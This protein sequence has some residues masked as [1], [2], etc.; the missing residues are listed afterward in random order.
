MPNLFFERN[1][2][3][4]G[5]NAPAREAAAPKRKRVIFFPQK[6]TTP[7]FRPRGGFAQSAGPNLG[8]VLYFSLQNLT[9]A[10]VFTAP[11]VGGTAPFIFLFF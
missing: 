11:V 10:P 5:Q 2:R 6:K 4:K 8:G 7:R 3:T 9:F 1:E